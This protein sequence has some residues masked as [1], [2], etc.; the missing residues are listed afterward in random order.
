[1]NHIAI[2]MKIRYG[3]WRG[4]PNRKHFIILWPA[5]SRPFFGFGL[6]LGTEFMLLRKLVEGD[7]NALV[8]L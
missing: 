7:P 4:R 3:H 8:L 6:A 2:I 5:R 1:M